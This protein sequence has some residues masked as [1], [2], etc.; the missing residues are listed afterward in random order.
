MRRVAK[1]MRKQKKAAYCGEMRK[2]VTKNTDVREFAGFAGSG[3]DE[4]GTKDRRSRRGEY[5]APE[6]LVL[7]DYWRKN[8]EKEELMQNN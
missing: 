1:S 6:G 8:P 5:F 3:C 2:S 7:R 4:N